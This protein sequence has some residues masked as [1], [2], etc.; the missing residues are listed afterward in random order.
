MSLFTEALGRVV[1]EAV[2]DDLDKLTTV[3]SRFNWV[4][5]LPNSWFNY[6][7]VKESLIQ[8]HDNRWWRM[9]VWSPLL[10]P[11]SCNMSW[12]SKAL[13]TPLMIMAYR[14]P[15]QQIHSALIWRHLQYSHTNAHALTKRI[16][17][18][19]SGS[20]GKAFAVLT[21]V[22]GAA[23]LWKY[24]DFPMPWSKVAKKAQPLTAAKTT[25]PHG[26]LIPETADEVKA[27][28]AMGPLMDVIATEHNWVNVAR[29][30]YHA[31]E[32]AWTTSREDLLSML[33]RNLLR[34]EWTDPITERTSSVVILM[35]KANRGIT[36]GHFAPSSDTKIKFFR[37]EDKDSNVS[38]NFSSWIGPTSIVRFG[39]DCAL[40]Y[41]P[42]GG[43]FRDIT[44]FFSDDDYSIPLAHLVWRARGTSPNTAKAGGLHDELITNAGGTINAI[45]YDLPFPPFPGLCGCPLVSEQP[46]R[47]ILGIHQAGDP[48]PNSTTGY[49]TRVKK[50][51]LLKALA[52]MEERWFEPVSEGVLREKILGENLVIS[53]GLH[54]KSPLRTM[55]HG[56]FEYVG[57]CPGRATFH[58]TVHLQP[59]CRSVEQE[60]G[61]TNTWRAPQMADPW[62]VTLN[63]IANASE[64]VEP[65]H[66][67]W[68]QNDYQA[69]V[70]RM[71]KE[72]PE[73]IAQVR[74]LT[75]L[76]AINGID[77]VRFLD[78][79][80]LKTAAGFGK[81]KKLDLLKEVVDESTGKKT[82][83]P[84]PTLE[85]EVQYIENCFL[86]GERCYTPFKLVFKDEAVNKEKMRAFSVGQFAFSLVTRMHMGYLHWLFKQSIEYSECAVGMNPHGPE[87][88]EWV[89][90]YTEYTV[91]LIF[92]G[93]YKKYDLTQASGTKGATAQLFIKLGA[94]T[95]LPQKSLQIIKG[96]FTEKMY[97]LLAA[98]GDLM[99][100]FGYSPSG[101]SGTVEENSGDNGHLLRASAHKIRPV[102][103]PKF[104]TVAK[105]GTYGD[106]VF[107]G[108]NPKYTWF[109][110]PAVSKALESWNYKF[111]PPDK[112]DSFTAQWCPEG[113]FLKMTS[114]VV[115][116]TDIKV[117]KL[118]VNSI[119]KP[120]MA[121]TKSTLTPDAQ[122]AVN[123]NGA[124]RDSFAHGRVFYEDM[125]Q[126]LTRVAESVNITPWCSELKVDYDS[127]LVRWKE[128]YLGDN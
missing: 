84:T 42:K 10:L 47:C 109:N 24:M 46:P 1:T 59:T 70:L 27:K 67:Q 78:P 81:Y 25:T 92:A 13:I 88:N 55:S 71:V 29:K 26:T 51:P 111:T 57:Q 11:L 14:R 5:W 110:A 114:G 50:T 128:R 96:I 103:T 33:Q 117:G 15:A 119:L 6:P 97:P 22:S 16:R 72:K 82:Y 118:D 77:G 120:L 58:S 86:K 53:K 107:G 8:Y 30:P 19:H 101:V 20:V 75:L 66:L 21:I 113:D 52:E 45:G 89:K 38:S 54:D 102:D 126:K 76:E 7:L 99:I 32:K 68:A 64:G 123:V 23:A 100:V 62:G 63:H 60:F 43:V 28:N 44:S 35:V 48:N 98:N 91:R 104:R 4:T 115:E 121:G 61:V 56:H 124:M 80:D 127:A 9:L 41:V 69:Q 40:V 93:D 39:E 125:R 90:W 112:S 95:P 65:N 106:D 79:M 37:H 116:G 73:L 122:C 17:E 18:E 83:H 108:V 34:M 94:A 2:E 87:W 31:S 105:L 74:P 85:A 3:M 49:A 36:V 12:S